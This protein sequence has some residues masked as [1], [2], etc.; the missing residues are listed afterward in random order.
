MDNKQNQTKIIE[1]YIKAYN[2]FDINEMC[3]NLSENIVFEN[4]SNEEVDLRIEGLKNFKQQANSSKKYFTSRNQIIKDWN[5]N[6][7]IVKI[8]IEYEGVIAIDF[9]NGMKEGDILKLT[10]ESEFTFEGDK[11]ISIK[12]KS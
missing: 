11:I 3:E 4:I 5:F 8:N 12:D 10:G 1:N 7:N 6:E 2:N 9:P